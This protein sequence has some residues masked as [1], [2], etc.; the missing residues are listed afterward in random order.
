KKPAPNGEKAGTKPGSAAV[1]AEGERDEGGE[2]EDRAAGTGVVKPGGEPADGAARAGAGA[3]AEEAKGQDE[4][5]GGGPGAHLPPPIRIPRVAARLALLPLV[6]GR[7]EADF[8]TEIAGG[9]ISGSASKRGG[10]YSVELE[11]SDI[12]LTALP[13]LRDKLPLPLKGTLAAQGRLL[14][15]PQEMAATN[16]RLQLSLHK[17]EL[18]AGNIPLPKGSLFPTFELTTPTRLGTLELEFVVGEEQAREPN[19]AL[20]TLKRFEHKGEDIELKLEGD[21]VLAAQPAQSRPDLTLG[22]RFA[23][24]FVERNHL[25]MVLASRDLKRNMKDDFLGVSLRGTVAHPDVKLVAPVWG[26]SRPYLRATPAVAKKP[27]EDEPQG[28][29]S[30]PAPGARPGL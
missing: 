27:A 9:S 4:A 2:G 3:V 10:A 29:T 23:D 25:K 17:A 24:P 5:M 1:V 22:V 7:L 12:V 11:M 30:A 6:I 20:A 13:G 21:V 14:W 19:M 28:K 18:G 16:G 8:V 26:K 15:S